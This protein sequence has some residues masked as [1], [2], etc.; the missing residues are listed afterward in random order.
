MQK[1]L[2]KLTLVALLST[3]FGCTTNTDMGVHSSTLSSNSTLYY[4]E[5]VRDR[6]GVS[7]GD[8]GNIIAIGPESATR[9]QITNDSRVYRRPIVCSD[10]LFV[11]VAE[12]TGGLGNPTRIESIDPDTGRRREFVPNDRAEVKLSIYALACDGN[13]KAWID[14]DRYPGM[15]AVQDALVSTAPLPTASA[16]SV[17]RIAWLP[18][19]D[20]LAFDYSPRIGGSTY[21]LALFD[22]FSMSYISTDLVDD[23]YIQDGHGS[24]R[25]VRHGG[26]DELTVWCSSKDGNLADL[27]VINIASQESRHLWR[28]TSNITY[29]DISDDMSS[30]YAIVLDSLDRRDIYHFDIVSGDSTRV[31]DDG[32]YKRDLYWAPPAEAIV[33]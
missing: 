17:R 4:V 13:R 14:Y 33:E 29:I 24:C 21:R 8:F 6:G 30:V 12:S 25:I 7:S 20:L 16:S 27:Y 28:N 15:L 22:A 31:S 23:G 26:P 32:R 3:V 2:S 5:D 10:Q 11:E 19:S 1:R 9:R 18:G